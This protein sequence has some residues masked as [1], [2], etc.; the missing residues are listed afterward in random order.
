ME[1]C[2]KKRGGLQ[3]R[4][5]L[6]KHLRF[7]QR[8]CDWYDDGHIEEAERI[9]VSLRVL[10]HS[11]QKATAL[12][13][14]LGMLNMKLPASRDP[15]A[16]GSACIHLTS[17]D[18]R[19]YPP[20]LVM[21][22]RLEGAEINERLT[23]KKWWED[24]PVYGCWSKQTRRDH[25]LSLANKDGAHFDPHLSV[26]DTWMRNFFDLRVE[27][28]R[29]VAGSEAKMASW[30]VEHALHASIRQIAYEVLLAPA[31]V[32]ALSV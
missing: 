19:S 26:D 15:A 6:R 27:I 21:V 12:V 25:V 2:K 32:R 22:P 14:Q 18:A 4:E 16:I 7:I 23:L 3:A 17:L 1:P 10:F 20:R 13:S 9:A 11:S 5:S 8:S 28:E 31:F 24:D 29:T 30:G